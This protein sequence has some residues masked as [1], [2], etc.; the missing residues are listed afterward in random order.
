[1]E[2]FKIKIEEILSRTV[3]VQADNRNEALDIANQ[4]YTSEEIVLDYNDLLKTE[5]IPID[6][7]N[8]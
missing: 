4:M 7:I 3:A 8:E 2:I 1:M 5:I 6:L